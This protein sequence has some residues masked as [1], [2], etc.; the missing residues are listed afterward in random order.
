MTNSFGDV[1]CTG[2]F[3]NTAGNK[4][5]A[6]WDGVNWSEYGG[7]NSLAAT[8]PIRDLEINYI[9]SVYCAGYLLNMNSNTYVA[10]YN[11]GIWQELG[12][13]NSFPVN[14][15][16]VTI[17]TDHL[18]NV[19]A[20]GGLTNSL[21]NNYVAKY[22]YPNSIIENQNG[23]SF[24]AYPNPALD[25]LQIVLSIKDNI[26]IG[27]ENTLGEVILKKIDVKQ[28]NLQIDVSSLEPGIYFLTVSNK[29]KS[30]TK[31]FIKTN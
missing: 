2:S 14:G 27:I 3:T 4:F 12:G 5:V 30:V 19:Y 29:N 25:Y 15:L 10:E 21:G 8:L 17:C 13:I 28:S 20:A 31:K 11:N 18:N 1:F 23:L 9:D 6:K 7:A 26:N 16:V 22:S 24:S